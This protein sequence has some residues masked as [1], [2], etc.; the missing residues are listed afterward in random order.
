MKKFV[1][2]LAP[3][4]MIAVLCTT[5]L[6]GLSFSASAASYVYNWGEREELATSLSQMAIDWYEDE[7]TSYDELSQLSG[8]SSTSSVPSSK[9]YKELYELMAG[10]Q[11]YKTS[12]N[13]TR[14]LFEYT[15]CENGN[16]NRISSF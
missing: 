5:L 4:L 8:S 13:A 6:S 11:T 2:V 10:A 16:G 15:D 3:L 1:K 12:Y 14:D 7:G 9:L